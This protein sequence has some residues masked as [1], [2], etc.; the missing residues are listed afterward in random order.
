MKKIFILTLV[1]LI[2]NNIFSQTSRNVDSLKKE[3][4][5]ENQLAQAKSYSNQSQNQW[6]SVAVVIIAGLISFGSAFALS[7]RSYRLERGKSKDLYVQ[8]HSKATRIAA[9]ELIKKVAQ[10][11][12]SLT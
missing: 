12:H 5:I 3:A 11:F 4:E 10:G 9:A 6:I 1:L 8:E 7:I 2:A